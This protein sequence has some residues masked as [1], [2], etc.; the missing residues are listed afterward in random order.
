MNSNTE[1]AKTCLVTGCAGFVGSHLC[2][3][4]LAAGHSVVGLDTLAT[5]KDANLAGLKGQPRFAFQRRDIREPGLLHSL[6]QA[7]PDLSVV[8]HLAAIVSVVYSMDHAR[9]TMETNH[10]AA[11]ALH[12]QARELGFDAFVFAGSAAEYGA[13]DALPLREDA[14]R[15][16]AA[17]TGTEDVQASPYGR[18]KYLTSQAI[19]ASGFGS[20]LRFFNIYGPRQDGDSPYA[21]VIARFFSLCRAGLPLTIRGDGRQGRDFLHVADAVRFL[22][23]A[24]GLTGGRKP[25]AG[26]FNV[27]TQRVTTVLELAH[28]VATTMGREPEL[29]FSPPQAGDIAQ[30]QADIGRLVA[31]TG[32]RPQV[33]IEEGLRRM[34]AGLV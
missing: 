34:G 14:I 6:R 15:T 7:Y 33:A 21:G 19:E 22:L 17:V 2:E 23:A 18:A 10:E 1:P 29:T 28:L 24:A 32:L 11:V 3:A 13:I 8:F 25:L 31:A 16:A 27:G 12:G 4:L 9:E 20:S 30:S 5:G 26:V